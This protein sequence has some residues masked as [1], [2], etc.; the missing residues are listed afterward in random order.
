MDHAPALERLQVACF[1]SLGRHEL[2]REEHFL[3]H[4]I[5]FPKGTFVA[6][7][8]DRVVG[9]SSGFLIDFDFSLPSHRFSEI[10]DRGFFSHHQ[11]HGQYY[12][13]ADVS[14][15]PDFRGQG[16]G[17]RLYDARK[18]LVARMELR[19]IVTGG[20]LPG[21]QTHPDLSVEQYVDKVVAGQIYDATLTFQLR[22]GFR[23][24]H[25]LENYIEDAASNNWAALM[26]WEPKPSLVSR[27]GS[28]GI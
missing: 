6:L 21:Y 17:R 13:G 25:L 1:P 5:V 3:R 11:A 18:D 2:M 7:S 28:A 23:F 26:V 16:I 19:G 12:Y 14:V 20:L 27:A 15:H 22:N 9:L 8:G 10:T 24:L 4:C